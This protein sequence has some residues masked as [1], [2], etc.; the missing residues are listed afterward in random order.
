MRAYT[1]STGEIETGHV[2]VS[3]GTCCIE[4]MLELDPWDPSGR[5]R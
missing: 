2:S 3:Q 5:K 1:P 4:R